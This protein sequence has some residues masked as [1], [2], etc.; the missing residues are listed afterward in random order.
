MTHPRGESDPARQDAVDTEGVLA[1]EG[2]LSVGGKAAVPSSLVTPRTRQFGD[3][4]NYFNDDSPALSP[5][6]SL[7]AEKLFADYEKPAMPRG[8][9]VSATPTAAGHVSVSSTNPSFSTVSPTETDSETATRGLRPD[10]SSDQI[11]AVGRSSIAA[12]ASIFAVG[13]GTLANRRVQLLSA[14]AVLVLGA[15]FFVGTRLPTL[16]GPAPAVA[17]TRTPSPSP[18]V[19][20]TPTPV[21]P[22]AIGIHQWNELG[23]GECIDP[24]AAP[25]AEKFTVVD[26]AVAHPAQ[27]VFRGTFAATADPSGTLP[28]PRTASSSVPSVPSVPSV[29]SASAYPGLQV[30]QSQITLLCTAQGILNL[31]LAGTYNDLLVQASYPA[32]AAQWNSGQRDYFCFI[33][34]TGGQPI[35]GSLVPSAG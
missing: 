20:V 6:D 16:A 22:A 19:T 34:R 17:V 12:R 11:S 9:T 2:A 31:A 24:F 35:T 29:A 33:T 30:I 25:F 15:L 26:C 10:E 32:T 4:R 23:G 13:A 7:F 28:A 21:G 8:T 3:E 27:M 1:D 5:I 18:S 14:L